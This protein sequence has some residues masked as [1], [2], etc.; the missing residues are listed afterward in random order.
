M[1]SILLCIS[2]GCFSAHAHST[3]RWR[4]AHSR[5]AMCPFLAS[6]SHS[7]SAGL[8]T[9]RPSDIYFSLWFQ[10]FIHHV[11]SSFGMIGR[12]LICWLLER[13]SLEARYSPIAFFWPILSCPFHSQI[14]PGNV[15]LQVGV[16]WCAGQHWE[17]MVR[18]RAPSIR[19][20][21]ESALRSYLWNFR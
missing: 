16:D 3:S 2:C 4:A 14:G 7:F 17:S 11:W 8:V 21:G 6:N 10:P 19:F 9:R 20:D 15:F 12:S 5:A 13:P 18:L 1:S